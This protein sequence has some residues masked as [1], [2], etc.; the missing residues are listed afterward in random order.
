MV[1]VA[2]VP[3][4]KLMERKETAATVASEESSD[5]LAVVVSDAEL[6]AEAE[7]L[8]KDDQL[9]PGARLV[10][11][12]QDE[13]LITDELTEFMT[14]A[15]YSEKLRV[16]LM[17]PVSEG[18]TKQG[19]SHGNR[20][21]ITYYKIEKGGK[22]KC[23]IESVIEA[24]L[25]VPFLAVLNETDIYASWIPSWRFPFKLGISS[26]KKLRQR[27]RVDQV[28]QLTVD[29]PRP[30]HN[31]EIVFWGFAEEDGEANRDVSAK[32]QT[33]ETGFD[34][35]LVPPP[36]KGVVRMDFEADF[37][38]RPCPDDHPALTKSKAKYPE[39]ESLI[40]LTFVM[41]CDP[42][43]NFVPRAFMNFC[44]RTAIGMVWNMILKVSEQVR[45][46]ER[47]EH[48]KIMAE[49]PTFYDWVASRSKYITGEAFGENK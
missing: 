26:S 40:L 44:T 10:R 31:R 41:Y 5:D 19:E 3:T 38:F 48:A 14:L 34:N 29:M 16:D 25:Y 4:K 42:K 13:S 22:L 15:A 35:G 8:F 6:V 27:G 7:R 46:G 24:S 1:A 17:E 9:L 36:D 12:I 32:L 39:G 37:L 45:A 21:F 49:K 20:D 47:P 33:V 11:K 43:V 18:W 28:V 30:L 2:A 23:R